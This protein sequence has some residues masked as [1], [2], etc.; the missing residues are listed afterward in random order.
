MIFVIPRKKIPKKF[1]PRN[2][3]LD[4]FIKTLK[5]D[6]HVIVNEFPSKP[7]QL[8]KGKFPDRIYYHNLNLDL[9]HYLKTRNLYL[10]LMPVIRGDEICRPTGR[11]TELQ[12][13]ELLGVI[14]PCWSL[15]TTIG[16]GDAGEICSILEKIFEDDGSGLF[17]SSSKISPPDGRFKLP[18]IFPPPAKPG[19]GRWKN[20]V[21]GV[22]MPP[23]RSGSL[24]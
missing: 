3:N 2:Y 20:G 24:N 7:M 14:I 17:I 12:T 1:K 19:S 16:T 22:S 11:S 21:P 4:Q 10:L 9:N 18:L 13:L 8:M 6:I 15:P 5:F 23:W